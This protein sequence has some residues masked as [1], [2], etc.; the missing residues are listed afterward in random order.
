MR[1]IDVEPIVKFIKDGLNNPNKEEAFGYTAVK[2]LTEIEY[3]PTVDAVEVVHGRWHHCGEECFV[4]SVC[5]DNMMI[6]YSYCPNCGAK[7]DGGNEDGN[8]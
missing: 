5:H 4:C 6:D 1:L 8:L 7:M 2:I 3:A